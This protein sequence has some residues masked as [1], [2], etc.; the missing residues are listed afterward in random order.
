MSTFHAW[1]HGGDESG[2]CCKVYSGEPCRRDN[3]VA[4]IS[5]PDGSMDFYLTRDQVWHLRDDLNKLLA[6]G[7]P[8][9][10]DTDGLHE[11]V[12]AAIVAVNR[13]AER[14]GLKREV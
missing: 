2:K 12:H 10:I 3:E 11:D 6:D 7:C 4:S 9:T 13:V 14:V 8:T 5:T 1:N